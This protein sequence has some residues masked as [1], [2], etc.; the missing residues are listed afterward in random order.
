MKR[1]VLVLLDFIVLVLLAPLTAQELQV[2]NVKLLEEDNEALEQPHYDGNHQPLALLK[3]YPE[4]VQDLSFAS[5]FIISN[6]PLVFKDGYYAVY[7]AQGMKELEIR[8]NDYYA[9]KVEFRKVYNI[10][11]KGG[12]TYRVDVKAVGMIQKN[13][14][15]VVFN[16]L[17]RVGMITINGEKHALSKGM[18]QLE[19]LPGSYTYKAEADYYE[20]KSG[21]FTVNEIIEPQTIPIRLNILTTKVRFTCNAP[22]AILYVDQANKGG[23][24]IKILPMGKHKIR[25]VARDWKDYTS[26][27]VIKPGIELNVNMIANSFVPFVVRVT[28]VTGASLYVDNKLVPDWKNGQ[29]FKVKQGKHLITVVTENN[30]TKEKV[31][32]VHAGIKPIDIVF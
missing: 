10:N 16:M 18:L 4:N 15:T 3:V 8:H 23:V 24:G 21:Q 9:V 22:N 14:Q 27:L 29:P 6:V 30:E 12:K 31:V 11:I 1:F 25:V 17:P 28:G 32:R 13:T 20:A 26:S 7:V 5:S 19:C 2:T